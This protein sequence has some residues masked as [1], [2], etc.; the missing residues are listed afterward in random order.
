MIYL[1]RPL[2]KGL[3]VAENPEGTRYFLGDPKNSLGSR[4]FWHSI[5]S[6]KMASETTF[7]I[8]IDTPLFIQFGEG[9]CI[10]KAPFIDD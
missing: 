4:P 5:P 9:M 1:L 6:D 10:E 8:L 2:E 7:R 3:P